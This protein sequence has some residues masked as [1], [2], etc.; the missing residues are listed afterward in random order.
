MGWY[1]HTRLGEWAHEPLDFHNARVM[2]DLSDDWAEELAAGAGAGEA[3]LSPSFTP[4]S[5]TVRT[6]FVARHVS[7]V[8][9]AGARSRSHPRPQ[10]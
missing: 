5:A 2:D 3:S 4:R 7:D 1:S 8:P 6:G 10:D 9:A